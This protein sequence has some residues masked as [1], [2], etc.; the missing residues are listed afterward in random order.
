MRRPFPPPRGRDNTEAGLPGGFRRLFAPSTYHSQP[1]AQ[2]RL[3]QKSLCCSSQSTIRPQG[4]RNHAFRAVAGCRISSGQRRRTTRTCGGA[5]GLFPGSRPGAPGAGRAGSFGDQRARLGRWHRR[6]YRT[7]PSV[8]PQRAR[9][10]PPTQRT[11]CPRA[12]ASL[13]SHFAAASHLCL[14]PCCVR[15]LPASSP[16][17][18]L[19]KLT[20]CPPGRLWLHEIKHDGFRVIA[21]KDGDRVRLYMKREEEEDWRRRRT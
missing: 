10:C 21:R 15:F 7:M 5:R 8:I 19:P 6:A 9:R 18:S 4:G 2:A 20:R 16:R 1:L 14:L 13:D 11:E 12:S 3:S 17:A